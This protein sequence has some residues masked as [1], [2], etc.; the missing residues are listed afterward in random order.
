MLWQ[1]IGIGE[2]DDRAVR[3]PKTPIASLVRQKALLVVVKPYAGYFRLISSLSRSWGELSTTIVSKSLKLCLPIA[4]RQRPI[5][6]SD[7]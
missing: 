1:A 3:T 4:S 6:A 2:D 7:L 5:V